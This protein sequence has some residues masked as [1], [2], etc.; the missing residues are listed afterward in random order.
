[1]IT[2][3]ANLAAL[4]N[5]NNITFFNTLKIFDKAG[6]V[7]RA[8]TTH[9]SDITL[10]DGV[11][12]VADGTIISLDP[13]TLNTTVD[14]E[15]YKIQLAD[16]NFAEGVALE[17]GLIAKF[18][19]VRLCFL[20]PSS[21][22]PYTSEVDTFIVYAGRIDETNYII[23]TEELGESVL[24]LVCA[25]PV[26]DLEHKKGIFLSRDFVRNRYLDD[27]CCDSIYE[28]SGSLAAKWGKS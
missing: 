9:N 20:N 26:A 19:E 11:T 18:C 17:A 12:Y 6:V 10:F 4:I 14:R 25:S 27:A 1:M 21:G 8:I 15:Q 5:A 2:L 13:P 23:K 16:P 24:Q 7:L 28:G 3:S 22:L